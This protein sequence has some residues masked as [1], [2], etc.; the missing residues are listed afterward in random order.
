VHGIGINANETGRLFGAFMPFAW[1][2]SAAVLTA[3]QDTVL[4]DSPA[5]RKALEYYLGLRGAGTIGMQEALDREF[6]AGRLGFEIAGTALL[7]RLAREAPSLRYGVTL[8]PRPAAGRGTHASFAEG[9]VLVS[10]ADSKR[11]AEALRLARFLARRD[12]SVALALVAAGALPAAAGADSLEEVRRHPQLQVAVRQLA[13]ASFAP[14]HPRWSAMEAA[15]EDEIEQ[16]LFDRKSASSAVRDAA[17]RL[18][19]LLGRD[20]G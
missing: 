20:P 1:G 11:K 16:A 8:L 3:G 9:E 13:T 4:F 6:I 2:D 18:A 12:N 14:T 7:A 5:T 15:I 17:A 10:F 19:E